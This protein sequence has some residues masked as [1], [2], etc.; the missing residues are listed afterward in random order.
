MATGVEK[1][2]NNFLRRW[3]AAF[4]FWKTFPVTGLPD[5][6]WTDA[7][8]QAWSKFLTSDT[9]AKLRHMRWNRIYLC[10]QQAISE[11]GNATYKCGVAFGVRAMVAEEDALLRVELPQ[12]ELN[13][14][15]SGFK[16]VNR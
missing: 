4:S 12:L 10:A 5:G 14:E 13:Q 2:M 1:A 16:S 3:R 8:S 7:D 6:Y 9:G 15:E 11:Q